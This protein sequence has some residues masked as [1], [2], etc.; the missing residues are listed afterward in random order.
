MIKVIFDLHLG[1]AILFNMEK[2]CNFSEELV[3]GCSWALDE[4]ITNIE[5]F[6]SDPASVNGLLKNDM[7]EK[8]FEFLS[9]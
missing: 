6:I 7:I 4:L 5:T 1:F 2:E 3:K 8:L 9:K